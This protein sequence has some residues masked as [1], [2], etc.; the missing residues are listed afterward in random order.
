MLSF[1][2]VQQGQAWFWDAFPG[3]ATSSVSNDS[4]RAKGRVATATLKKGCC[5]SQVQRTTIGAGTQQR[6]LK[7][8]RDTVS[9]KANLQHRLSRDTRGRDGV[10]DFD[11]IVSLLALQPLLFD[12][13]SCKCLQPHAHVV[14]NLCEGESTSREGSTVELTAVSRGQWQTQVLWR[15]GWL[16]AGIACKQQQ[17]FVILDYVQPVPGPSVRHQ[18]VPKALQGSSS[19]E[20]ALEAW[21]DYQK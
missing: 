12:L 19:H 14:F 2:F 11:I 18:D 20:L 7:L 13:T 8:V 15:P 1:C 5:I 10:D 17:Q 16:G 6:S 3:F 9:R 4:E 21:Q